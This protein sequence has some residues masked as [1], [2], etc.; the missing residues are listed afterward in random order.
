MHLQASLQTVF[1]GASS[2]VIGVQAETGKSGFPHAGVLVETTLE[3]VH[4]R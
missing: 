1:Q 3:L 4:S 2:G